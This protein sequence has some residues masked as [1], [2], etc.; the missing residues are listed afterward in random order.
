MMP[1]ASLPKPVQGALLRL[2]ADGRAQSGVALGNA[3]GLSRAAIWKQVRSLRELGL[4]IQADR[5]RGY[6]LT[7]PLEL[8]DAGQIRANLPRMVG[9]A[10]TRLDVLL[11]TD[12]TNEHLAR[13]AMPLPGELSACLAEYQSGGRGR[14]GRR[15][16]SPLGHGLCL[17][18][19]WRF[20]TAPRDLPALSLVAGVA[21]AGALRT[22][23]IGKFGLKWPNDLV[24]PGEDHAG[25]LRGK[26]GGIL[27]EVAGES[28]GPLRVIVGIGLNVVTADDLVSRVVATPGAAAPVALDQL[29]NGVSLSRNRLA[30]ALIPA[31]HDSLMAF[32]NAGFSSFLEA[33]RE[34]DALK[35]RPVTV[36]GSGTQTAGVAHGIAADGSLLLKRGGAVLAI[37]SG[38]VTLRSC[39]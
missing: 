14:R 20:D 26:L 19:A 27:V 3:L 13:L 39:A 29:T 11:T 4:T 32:G 16:L 21:A 31:L 24:M 36:S 38:D 34:L 2:L 37:Q 22:L 25:Q 28:G 30:A 5:R 23:G 17:S 10:L 8:L 6:G 1:A 35:G 18:V 33:Y 12:S 15:W 9:A 7:R